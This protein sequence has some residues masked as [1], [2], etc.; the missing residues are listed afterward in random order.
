MGVCSQLTTRESTQAKDMFKGSLLIKLD[1]KKGTKEDARIPRKKHCERKGTGRG[2][3]RQS[4]KQLLGSKEFRRPIL[5]KA[6]YNVWSCN[7]FWAEPGEKRSPLGAKKK[8]TPVQVLAR[9][10]REKTQQLGRKKKAKE[11]PKKFSS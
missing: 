6:G 8:K 1:W 3:K 4:L 7:E 9:K 10:K 5:E 11:N 2:E